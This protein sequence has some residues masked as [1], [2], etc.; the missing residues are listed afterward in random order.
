[1]KNNYFYKSESEQFAFYRI[2]KL[3]FTDSRYAGISVEA[4]ILY[5]LMLDRMSLSV[6]NNWVDDDNRVYIYFTLE[7]ITDYLS[8]VKDKGVKLLKELD[9]ILIER[10]KQGLGKPVMI[11]VLNFTDSQNSVR[12]V[13]NS[14]EVQTSD[15]DNSIENADF[16]TS[17]AEVRTSEKPKSGENAE[18]LTSEIP[19]SA[20]LKNRTLDFGKS[21]SNNTDINNT[22]L[23]N[24]DISSS[25]RISFAALEREREEYRDVIKTNIEYDILIQQYAAEKIDSFVN[26]IVDALCSFDDKINVNSM[27]VPKEV[28]KS[29]LLK[30]DYMHI[31]YVIDCLDENSSK[32]RNYKSY[33]LTMLYNA[34]DT[35]NH[36]YQ[37]KFNKNY[38]RKDEN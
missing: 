4:K 33:I 10:K 20:L 32:I 31:V 9:G 14:A 38:F 15:V 3:L 6:R 23:N 28:V 27:Q 26:I 19:K 37:S 21:D 17:N 30:L 24:T 11:Y 5:G 2:P 25:S 8:I 7:E 18:V 22:D 16:G 36:Y 34:P 12:S 35:M 1:M 29:K 13:D